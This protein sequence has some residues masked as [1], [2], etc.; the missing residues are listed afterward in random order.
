MA[1]PPGSCPN[2]TRLDEGAVAQGVPG[3]IRG[4]GIAPG[5]VWGA[6]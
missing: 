6:G 1:L 3:S 2:P 4:V 5:G